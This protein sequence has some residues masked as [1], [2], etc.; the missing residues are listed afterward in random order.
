[1][2]IETALTYVPSFLRNGLRQTPSQALSVCLLESSGEFISLP[3]DPLVEVFFQ[4][5]FPDWSALW[6]SCTA[7]NK[8]RESS[9]F[10]G[11]V[12]SL[13]N[14]FYPDVKIN[15]KKDEYRLCLKISH[16]AIPKHRILAHV[17]Y[18][19]EHTIYTKN[20][21]QCRIQDGEITTKTVNR[22][23]VNRR[24]FIAIFDNGKVKVLPVPER[25]FYDYQM[26][27][28]PGFAMMV[29]AG[30]GVSILLASQSK[31]VRMATTE[32]AI[33]L[34]SDCGECFLF[35]LPELSGSSTKTVDDVIVNCC[36]IGT[37][38]LL[39]SRKGYVKLVS[40]KNHIIKDYRPDLCFVDIIGCGVRSAFLITARGNM[41]EIENDK[42][43][44][45]N[46][47]QYINIP[48]ICKFMFFHNGMLFMQRDGTVHKFDDTSRKTIVS[49]SRDYTAIDSI[50]QIDNVEL[51]H[52]ATIW[53]GVTYF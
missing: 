48:N 4:C 32:D 41:L 40:A 16:D 14:C 17:P 30:V 3:E 24:E 33:F 22:I 31:I 39:L 53:R 5:P 27:H 13:I 35:S 6:C 29:G 44:I 23:V 12:R 11:R 42:G 51:I 34:L 18:G 21:T 28:N 9:V 26:V 20:N 43:D 47:G 10:T 45:I 25:P 8:V 19:V 49:S 37:D 1:M 7:L 46:K 50:T 36:T 38:F 52:R 15:D 2:D